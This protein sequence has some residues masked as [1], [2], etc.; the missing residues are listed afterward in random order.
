MLNKFKE[1]K[2]I[3]EIKMDQASKMAD[4]AAHEFIDSIHTLVKD[5]SEEDLKKFLQAEDDMI[6]LEDKLAVIAAFAD[7]HDDI[8]GAV[9]I[10][11]ASMVSQ[12][13]ALAKSKFYR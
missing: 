5:A 6:E 12:S 2:K 1:N 4:E 11:F 3:M 13:L 10:G 8:D 7:T 9:I